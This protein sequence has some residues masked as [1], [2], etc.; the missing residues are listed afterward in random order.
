MSKTKSLLPAA[1]ILKS[2]EGGCR[3]NLFAVLKKRFTFSIIHTSVAAADAQA[4]LL[5]RRMVMG[6]SFEHGGEQAWLRDWEF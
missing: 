3:D 2:Q 5:L 4:V 6:G 1:T